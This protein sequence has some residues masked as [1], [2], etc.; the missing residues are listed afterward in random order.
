MST[1]LDN[2][3]ILVKC[4]ERFLI[5]SN[6]GDFIDEVEFQDTGREL[7]ADLRKNALLKN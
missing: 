2:G 3:D 6:K 4:E 7:Y 5:Y 1:F